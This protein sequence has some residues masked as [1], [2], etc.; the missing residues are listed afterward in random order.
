MLEILNLSYLT[1]EKYTEDELPKLH[2]PVGI[3]NT[4]FNNMVYYYIK[5]AENS[6]PKVAI[7]KGVRNQELISKNIKDFKG[8]YI[9]FSIDPNGIIESVSY[10]G[11]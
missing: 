1:T 6:L 10:Y 2:I 11:S 7:E 8:H 3:G 9:K 5:R 4:L